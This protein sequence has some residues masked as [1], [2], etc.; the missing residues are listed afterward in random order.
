MPQSYPT[1]DGVGFG[2]C[3]FRILS[4]ASS[5]TGAFESALSP[6][7]TWSD[8]A[9]P[10]TDIHCGCGGMRGHVIT[11]SLDQTCK[12]KLL[13]AKCIAILLEKYSRKLQ[14]CTWGK[15]KQKRL[16][17]SLVAFH[18]VHCMPLYNETLELPHTSNSLAQKTALIVLKVWLMKFLDTFIVT[19]NGNLLFQ[20]DL[21]DHNGERG[22]CGRVIVETVSWIRKTEICVNKWQK[23][24]IRVHFSQQMFGLRHSV[25]YKRVAYV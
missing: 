25:M 12:V 9:L 8:H 11:S 23:N 2:I 14:Q 6:Y 20:S 7:Y 5:A 15:R 3:F 17:F 21:Y 16:H 1:N 22:V 19:Y 18:I 4:L 10:V 13:I 24:I